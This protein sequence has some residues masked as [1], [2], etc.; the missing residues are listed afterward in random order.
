MAYRVTCQTSRPHPHKGVQRD[1]PLR[2]LQPGDLVDGK[3]IVLVGPIPPGGPPCYR[4][5]AI[6]CPL[7]GCYNIVSGKYTDVKQGSSMCSQCGI[8]KYGKSIH[9][10]IGQLKKA[11]RKLR[12]AFTPTHVLPTR[13]PSPAQKKEE[14]DK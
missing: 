9:V 10:M 6:I 4:R 2:H 14:S 8:K 13:P 11:D 7:D 5:V 12:P 1:T 3:L